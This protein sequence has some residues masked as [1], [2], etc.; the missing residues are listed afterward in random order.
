MLDYPNARKLLLEFLV[1]ET[2]QKIFANAD[3]LPVNPAVP[4]KEARLTPEGGSFNAF[5][6]T[7]EE[8][9]EQIGEWDRIFK[10]LFK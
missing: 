9:D 1:S 8:F 3:Y 5:C 10:G 6:L 7:P 2:G 4:A